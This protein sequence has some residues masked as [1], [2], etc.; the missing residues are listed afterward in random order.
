MLFKFGRGAIF[1]VAAP[2]FRS[3]CLQFHNSYP[4]VYKLVS[5]QFNILK[6]DSEKSFKFLPI[7][8]KETCSI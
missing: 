3:S 5:R 1:K 7:V 8:S 2:S 4:K 6:T